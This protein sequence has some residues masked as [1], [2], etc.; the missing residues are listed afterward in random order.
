M[1]DILLGIASS[2][3]KKVKGLDRPPVKKTNRK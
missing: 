1:K 3:N 2:Q